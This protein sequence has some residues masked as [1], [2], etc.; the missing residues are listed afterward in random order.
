MLRKLQRKFVLLTTLIS[1]IVLLFIGMA[2][3]IINY[4]AMLSYSDQVLELLVHDGLLITEEKSH[5][6]LPKEFAFTTRFFVVH[7][8]S[9]NKVEVIDTKNISSISANDATSYIQ[10]LAS[11]GESIGIIDNF[12]F[13]KV[14]NPVGYTYIF[15]DIEKDIMN[16]E[17]YVISSVLIVGLAIVFIFILSCLLSKKAV[18]PIVKSYEKQKRFIT[19]VSHEFK[20]PLSII[21]ADC[22][23]LELDYGEGE[24]T[25]SIK[26][27]T[28]RLNLLVEDLISLT[29]LEESGVTMPK[30]T[31]TLSN[32][33]NDTLAEFSSRIQKEGI[34]LDSEIKSNL[35]YLGNEK[36]IQK[37]LCLLIE[38]AIKYS[39][40]YMKVELFTLGNK[41]VLCIENSCNSIKVGKYNHWFERFYR[42]DQSRNSEIKG[43]GIGLSIAKSICDQHGA[44]IQAESKTGKEIV[45]SVYF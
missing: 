44:K 9:E 18:S 1:S 19:D 13:Q 16:F 36:Y 38:N 26:S 10:I 33:V 11:K 17:K 4:S 34:A 8:D 35:V 28:T 24:W 21:K 39:A 2:I 3:N 42:E 29:R 7:T 20:T 40:G 22:E 23:V 25:E 14:E 41:K 5:P 15:L 37:L 12:R 30:E 27:Q 32:V 43:F 31:F 45:I 6:I